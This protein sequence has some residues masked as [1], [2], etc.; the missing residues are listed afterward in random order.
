MKKYINLLL[1]V[2]AIICIL[3][4]VLGG[5]DLNFT[6]ELLAFPFKAMAIGL[7]ELSFLGG[8][9]N[10]FAWVIFILVCSIPIIILIV[11]IIK[12]SYNLHMYYIYGKTV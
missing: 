4:C 8:I 9:A 11:K 2:E 6:S 10:I 3:V 1:I 12:N 7:R 5:G